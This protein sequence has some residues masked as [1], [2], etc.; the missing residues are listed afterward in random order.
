MIDGHVVLSI[1]DY[2]KLYDAAHRRIVKIEELNYSG[3]ITVTVDRDYVYEEATKL[4]TD[5]QL[6]EYELKPQNEFLVY[7]TAIA[8]KIKSTE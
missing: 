4:L 8:T 6:Q 7:N 5:K 3:E 1:E 2:N